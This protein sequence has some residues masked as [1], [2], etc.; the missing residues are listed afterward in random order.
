MRWRYSDDFPGGADDCDYFRDSDDGDN[1][2]DNCDPCKD[3]SG[4]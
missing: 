3:S 1:D 2:Y 4:L